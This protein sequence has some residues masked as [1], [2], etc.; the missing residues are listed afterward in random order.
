LDVRAEARLR[1]GQST[2]ARLNEE[3]HR[4]RTQHS[5]ALW[6]ARREPA[7]T[8]T[9]S[10]RERGVEARLRADRGRDTS[11]AEE[12]FTDFDRLSRSGHDFAQGD[13]KAMLRVVVEDESTSL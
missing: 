9:G 2:T 1:S 3:K 10:E 4:N 7:G 12:I 11:R 6:N 8:G 5:E 13:L